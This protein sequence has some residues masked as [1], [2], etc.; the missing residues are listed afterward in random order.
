MTTSI[1]TD[2]ESDDDL[3]MLEFSFGVQADLAF[4]EAAYQTGGLS[5]TA[6]VDG[7]NVNMRAARRCMRW[8]IDRVSRDSR[9]AMACSKIAGV[10]GTLME[11]YVPRHVLLQWR[12]AGLRAAEIL[13][14][15]DEQIG[16]ATYLAFLHTANN[17]TDSA[18]MQA[19]EALRLARISGND[20][21]IA[22]ALHASGIVYIHAETA[23]KAIDLLNEAID[24]F[25]RCAN[26]SGLLICLGTLATCYAHI[27][28]HA[29]A[30]D[31]YLEALGR[32]TIPAR[33]GMLFYN[34][35]NSLTSEHRWEEARSYF[36][37]AGALATGSDDGTLLGLVNLGYAMWCML[38]SDEALHSTA[39]AKLH[40]AIEWFRRR[41]ERRH[42]IQALHILAEVYRS[43]VKLGTPYEQKSEALKGLCTTLFSLEDADGAAEAA[44]ELLDLAK[45]NNDLGD[46]IDACGAIGRCA[47]VHRD[48]AAARDAFAAALE[49]LGQFK[50][51]GPNRFNDAD[52]AEFELG[53][54]Q[55]YR[56]LNISDGAIEHYEKGLNLANALKHPDLQHRASGNLGLIYA[57]SG[58]YERALELLSAVYDY[59]IRVVGDY[60]LGGHALFNL[61]YAEYRCGDLKTAV[62]CG[63]EAVRSL[64]LIADVHAPHARKQLETWRK[65]MQSG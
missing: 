18:R 39:F 64:E 23:D 9:A 1:T 46:Q 20:D 8:C 7:L 5:V 33:R 49:A 12:E 29:R 50:Q 14:A 22:T 17:N 35:A 32:E 34:L 44:Q 56:H 55:A 26:E 6:A 63:D 37:A 48:F 42:E 24:L 27:G 25:R 15:I 3:D 62:A 41:N 59:Y 61:A 13:G 16:H 52:E 21:F 11:T 58:N 38:Q 47:L 10:A 30:I 40:T 43:A 45:A 57:D 51:R 36:E 31:L 4:L 65:E 54:G 28:E 53:I 60:R 19:E 2:D